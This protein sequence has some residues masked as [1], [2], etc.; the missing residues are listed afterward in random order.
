MRYTPKEVILTEE[1]LRERLAYW[2]PVMGL[3][4]WEI[5]LELVPPHKIDGDYASCM[6]RSVLRRA[7]VSISDSTFQDALA[8]PRDMELDLVHEL[9]HCVFG[10]YE[11]G[12]GE[13]EH[14]SH[15]GEW[16]RAIE[17]AAKA[18]IATHRREPA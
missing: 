4:D 6:P 12:R 17:T 1:E 3:A 9:M 5:R 2:Q 8:F 16:E 7:V 14:K 15:G 10:E 11:Y 13:C 18:V